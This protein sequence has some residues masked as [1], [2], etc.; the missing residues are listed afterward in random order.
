MV[1]LAER[2]RAARDAA[3]LSTDMLASLAGIDE[4]S[5]A[6]ALSRGA[7]L[8]AAELDRC[9]RVFGV[10]VEDLVQGEATMSPLAMLLRSSQEEVTTEL[11]GMVATELHLGLG[12]FL[13]VVRDITDLE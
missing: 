7:A 10:R 4:P 1:D 11:R 8:N 3:G 13:R 2:L 12:E 6:A 5:L 9:A